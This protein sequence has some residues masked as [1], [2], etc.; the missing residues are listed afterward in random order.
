M[1]LF[2]ASPSFDPTAIVRAHRSILQF[3]ELIHA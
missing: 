2:N 3:T 1:P